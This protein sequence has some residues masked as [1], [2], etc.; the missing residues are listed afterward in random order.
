MNKTSK[1]NTEDYREMRLRKKKKARLR[2]KK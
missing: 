2:R 1:F